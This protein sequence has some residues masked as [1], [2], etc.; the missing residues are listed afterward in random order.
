V[1]E[2][3]SGSFKVI[4]LDTHVAL[5]LLMDPDK[6]S[7]PA[8]EAVRLERAGGGEISCSLISL[9]EIGYAAH[10]NRLQ[11]NYPIREFLDAVR[12]K[13]EIAPLT[14]E[15][16]T[17]AAQLAEPFHGDPMDRMIA[18]TAMVQG[19]ALITAD[20]GIQGAGV[21]KTIW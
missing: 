14:F 10:R 7:P 8:A 21:C 20:R 11:L 1:G 15:I 5:W 13:L 18:A 12:D 4:L 17:C 9:Y 3:R 6:L 2:S 19:C 16:V